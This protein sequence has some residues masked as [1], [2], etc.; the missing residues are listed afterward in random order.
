MEKEDWT[1]ALIRLKGTSY[2]LK[3]SYNPVKDSI[4]QNF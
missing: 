1:K 4:N 2:Y 3:L